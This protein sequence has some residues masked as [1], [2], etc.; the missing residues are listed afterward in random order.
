TIITA[1]VPEP[2]SLSLLGLGAILGARFLRRR[3]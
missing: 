1:V 3:A 2:T